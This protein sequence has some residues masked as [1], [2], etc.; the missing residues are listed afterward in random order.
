MCRPKSGESFRH[1]GQRDM[2]G[3]PTGRASAKAGA[4]WPKLLARSDRQIRQGLEGDPEV[5][6]T[7]AEFWNKARV[8]MPC[9]AVIDCIVRN[10]TL[11]R[12][13]F[14]E[15]CLHGSQGAALSS[16]RGVARKAETAGRR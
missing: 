13:P 3:K 14:W 2:K 7:D 9:H 11:R 10:G 16:E 6:P 12:N 8:V 1:G 15:I 5:R 4:D